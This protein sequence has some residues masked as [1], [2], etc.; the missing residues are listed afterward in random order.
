MVTSSRQGY[1]AGL[2]TRSGCVHSS[3]C[4]SSVCWLMEALSLF[5]VVWRGPIVVSVNSARFLE[6]GLG[7]SV[8]SFSCRVSPSVSCRRV[9]SV[10]ARKVA[11]NV[12][13]S[14]SSALC[15]PSAEYLLFRVSYYCP[16]KSP[17]GVGAG[18]TVTLTNT[19]GCLQY[20]FASRDQPRSFCDCVA[21][22]SFAFVWHENGVI[23]YQTTQ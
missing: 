2:L 16:T 18:L 15:F 23:R 5:F 20:P 7:S 13:T 12:E 8:G 1:V 3:L 22:F 19:S 10:S 17:G 11:I 14:S 4:S 21:I 9:P 6:W